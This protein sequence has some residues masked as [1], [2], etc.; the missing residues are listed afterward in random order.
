MATV[1][2]MV[3]DFSRGVCENALQASK[4]LCDV[5]DAPFVGALCGVLLVCLLPLSAADA[6]VSLQEATEGAEEVVRHLLKLGVV[7]LEGS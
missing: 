5:I 7:E 4:S 6:L 3:H 2:G 1:A